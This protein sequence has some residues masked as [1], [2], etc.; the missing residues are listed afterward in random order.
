[1][2]PV[3][4]V[5][6]VDVEMTIAGVLEIVLE[7]VFTALPAAIVAIIAEVEAASIAALISAISSPVIVVGDVIAV[8]V[9]TIEL[10][11]SITALVLGWACA[12]PYIEASTYAAVISP[13][14][15]FFKC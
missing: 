14:V 2:T 10:S 15:I 1:M 8:L 11:A 13:F 12:G 6:C 3:L 9:E 5:N 7:A 4:S